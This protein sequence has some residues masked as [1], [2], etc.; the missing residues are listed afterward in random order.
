M[1]YLNLTPYH[2]ILELLESNKFKYNKK[3]TIYSLYN[4]NPLIFNKYL[5]LHL[6]QRSIKPKILSSDFDQIDQELL[7]INNNLK[8]KKFDI[9]II[10]SDI[11]AKLSYNE[12]A[13]DSYINSQKNNLVQCLKI[14]NKSKNLPIIFFNC[15]IL[16]A[17]F[18]SS[19]EKF[20]KLSKKIFS[21]NQYLHKLSLKYKSLKILDVNGIR[22]LIGLENFYDPR[23]YYISKTPYSQ[24][25]NNHI[26]FELSQIIS[27]IFITRKKCLVLDL[28]N[29][30]WGGILG[31]D[32][33][34]GIDLGETY[35]GECFRN[36]Q[37]YIK[38]LLNK[39]IILAIC[40]KNNIQDVRECFKKNKEMILNFN[41]FSSVQINWTEKYLN[42]NKI[43]EELNIGKDSMVFFDDSIF[44]REQM[45]KFNPTVNVIETPKDPENFIQ[46]IENSSF[47]YQT[48]LTDEDKKKKYQYEIL[49]K[50]NKFKAK[51][52][53]INDFLKDLSM[54]LEITNINKFNFERSVQLTNK[55]NQ[56][57]L[58][59]KRY[60]SSELQQFL[61]SKN[62]I[63]LLVRLKDKFGD[64]GLTA[65]AMAKKVNSKTWII[66][67]FL[68]SCRI[69]GRGVENVLLY[70]L[71]KKLKKK[72]VNIV[73]G[74]YIKTKKNQQCKDFFIKNSF[75]KKDRAYICELN[76]LRKLNNSFLK[77]KYE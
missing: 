72:K 73:K 57:N 38:I 31:E 44:E 68:L 77:I 19:K 74:N 8:S 12:S 14:I 28:D 60:S 35:K 26:S 61:K 46:A 48:S 70:E 52:K 17:A 4:F 66:D 22:N 36:F 25:S 49:K 11:N 62:Q 40:S 23:N 27:S 75:I 2:K 20:T 24:Q 63:S 18:F 59:T 32:G 5:E 69:L 37:K 1:K 21:F 51:T 30:L 15:S 39:G 42:I 29:T 53:N 65:L 43:S 3:I 50:V 67:N 64:H 13:I 55:V 9:L 71:L 41:D 54:T 58:T 10:G 56:F 45:K 7:S 6:K 33:P 76:K 47:F 34:D 16:N